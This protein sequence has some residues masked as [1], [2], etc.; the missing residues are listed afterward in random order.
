MQEKFLVELFEKIHDTTGIEDI[1]Y[2]EIRDGRLKPI[3]KTKT[4][5]LSA[6]QWKDIHAQNVI[7]IDEHEILM[8][9]AEEKKPIAISDVK[10]DKLSSKAFFLFGIDSILVVPVMEDEILKGIVCIASIGQP[11]EFTFEEIEKCEA[12]I[13]DYMNR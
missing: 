7:Y 1:G 5:V 10:S 12:L 6:E 11:H 8:K 13:Q 2:H 9:I 3:Y 4:N